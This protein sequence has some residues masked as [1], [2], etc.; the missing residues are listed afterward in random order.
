MNSQ[1]GQSRSRFRAIWGMPLVLAV[2]T[3]FGLLA[4]LI[5]TGAWHWVA[6]LAL[7]VP[8]VVAARYGFSSR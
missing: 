1:T 7:T 3:V 2:L 4:A 8:L 6:W 5:G